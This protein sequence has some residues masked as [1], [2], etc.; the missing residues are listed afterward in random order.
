MHDDN[1]QDA[2]IS[3]NTLIFSQSVIRSL[4]D[5][6]GT[7]FALDKTSFREA[8]FSSPFNM[9]AYIHF[10]GAIQGEYIL[11]LDEITAAI[12]IE[13]YEVGMSDDD[14]REIRSDYA[15]FIKELL[16]L[17]VGQSISELEQSFGYLTYAPCTVVYG[18]IEFPDIMSGNVRIKSDTREILCGFALD[19]AKVKTG[20][21]L[22]ET[23]QELEK[24]TIEANKTRKEVD[25]I[26]QLLPSALIAVNSDGK[27]I[28]GHGH[29][30]ASVLG[31]DS[32]KDIVGSDLVS[33][34]ELKEDASRV[35]EKFFKLF[36]TND[37]FPFEEFLT[38]CEGK[39]VSQ[40]GKIFKLDWLPV[41]NDD[42]NT[43]DKLLVI[44][45]D[46]TEKRG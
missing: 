42:A 30:A 8:A 41:A 28:P 37:S 2:F 5:M 6:I 13:A 31:Y 20:R 44:I 15:D 17:A 27:I 18:E 45:E 7:P 9:I 38:M 14:L 23:L 36:K 10:A 25:T 39:F 19:F 35:M 43:L 4:E 1:L 34:L 11:S 24:K 22:E 40:R 12:L 21:K 3:T 46:I 26:L 29:K 32:D 16:N 33:L